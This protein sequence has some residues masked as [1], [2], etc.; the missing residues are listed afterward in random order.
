[1]GGGFAIVL[2]SSYAC[3]GSK[4]GNEGQV[5]TGRCRARTGGDR[6]ALALISLALDEVDA[7]GAVR[8]HRPIRE[9]RCIGGLS[10]PMASVGVSAETPAPSA[11]KRSSPVSLVPSDRARFGPKQAP[12]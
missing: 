3:G 6:C 2:A 4:A 1:M 9:D 11:A 10:A 8:G 12:A 7:T 5:G